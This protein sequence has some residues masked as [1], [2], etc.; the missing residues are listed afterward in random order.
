MLPRTA[1]LAAIEAALGRAPVV[2]LLGRR[3][4]EALAE[5]P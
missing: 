5:R 3:Q 1:L 2:G 4:G